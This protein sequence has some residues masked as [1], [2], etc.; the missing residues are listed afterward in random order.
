MKL[1]RFKDF[2][3]GGTRDDSLTTIEMLNYLAEQIEELQECSCQCHSDPTLK[4]TQVCGACFSKH[5][6]FNNNSGFHKRGA[7]QPMTEEKAR[8]VLERFDYVVGFFEKDGSKVELK[9]DEYTPLELKA[10]A[11]W[12]ENKK[13]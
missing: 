9:R 8:E 2:S 11:W 6:R 3:H 13:S 5:S 10:I 12:M 1:K 7:D 4:P